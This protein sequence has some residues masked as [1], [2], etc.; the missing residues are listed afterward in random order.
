MIKKL[1]FAAA[2]MVAGTTASHADDVGY[3]YALCQMFDGSNLLSKPC[4]VSGWSSAV[5]VTV[6]MNSG[7]ARKL[8][9]M[10]TNFL[11]QQSVNFEG[12]WTLQIKSPYSGD[13]SIAYCQL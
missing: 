8:C 11:A 6:D 5:V 10:I 7:E 4:E 3:A 2:I 12:S 1:L 9:P 13:N